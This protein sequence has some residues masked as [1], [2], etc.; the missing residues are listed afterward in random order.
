MSVETQPFLESL[1]ESLSDEVGTAIKTVPD[2]EDASDSFA[3]DSIPSSTSNKWMK[4]SNV[5][6]VV[7]DLKGSTHLGTGRHDKSTARIY[8]SSVEGAVR[9][10]HEFG[11]DFIDIQG[12]GGFGLFWGDRAYERALCA[13][14]TIRTFSEDLVDQLSSTWKEIPET[15]YKVGMH[16]ARTLVKRIGTKRNVAEQEAVWVGKAVNFAAKCAQ[17][18]DRHQVVATQD[19]WSRFQKNEYVAYSCGCNGEPK[20][21]LWT[22]K[23]VEKLPEGEQEAVVLNV[24][25]CVNCGP[26]FCEAIMQG[27]TQRE[28]VTDTARNALTQTKMAAALKAKEERERQRR[29]QRRGLR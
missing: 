14:V 17:S 20:A 25:W 3:L 18:A 12:D 7:C 1:L 13:A 10:F 11:A 8:K 6:A 5:V 22:D 26:S 2:V 15:G 16:A 29:I 28:D 19:V 4:L 21:S 23:T 27:K 9:I 24:P